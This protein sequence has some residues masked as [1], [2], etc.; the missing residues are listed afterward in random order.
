[1]ID[2]VVMEPSSEIF[3]KACQLAKALLYEGN[4]EVQMS[5][6]QRL[7]QKKIASKF[8]RALINK[9]QTAQNRLKSD[10]MSEKSNRGKSG[11]P[12]TIT[13]SSLC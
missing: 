9:L 11:M 1:M 7:K 4:H 6:Y 8:F 2:L 10:M 13:F 12:T 3:L 5:F